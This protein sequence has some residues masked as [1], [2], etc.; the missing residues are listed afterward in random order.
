MLVIFLGEAFHAGFPDA[1]VAV[2]ISRGSWVLTVTAD[3]CCSLWEALVLHASLSW[4]LGFQ[5]DLL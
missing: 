3:G 4:A 2:L 5:L 1:N